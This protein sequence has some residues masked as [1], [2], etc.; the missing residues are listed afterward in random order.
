MNS[1]RVDESAGRQGQ[2]KH[3][4]WPALWA[5]TAA[6]GT[7]FC[8]YGFRK[9]FTAAAYADTKFQGLDFKTVLVIAQVFGYM[10]SKFLGIKIV[11]EVPPQRRAIS[12]LA[13]IV[14]AEIA[15]VLF[16]LVSRPWNAGCLILNGLSLGMVFGLVIGFLEG[17]R[18]T[19][20]LSAGLCASFIVADGVTKSV[21]AWLLKQGVAEDWM[22]SAAGALYFL[23]FLLCVVMLTRIAPP[24]TTDIIA[25]AERFTMTR[26]ERWSFILKYATGL[27]PLLIVFLLVTVVRSI[28]A[29]F[30]REIWIGLGAP[31]EPGTFTRSELLVAIGVLVINGSGVLIADNRRAFST[32]LAV[33]GLGLVLLA[34]ALV[35]WRLR[36]LD[37]F[38]FM[39]L[40]GLG[41]YLPYVS[42]HT[43]VFERFLAL[44]RDRGNLGFL[45]LVADSL[46]YL[47][48][49]A[50]MV[51]RNFGKA[52]GDVVAWFATA[53]WTAVALSS[54]CLVVSWRQ[55]AKIKTRNPEPA[56]VP[57]AP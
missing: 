42:M 32:S 18:L 15:L 4:W 38:G 3:E 31:A 19:E 41:L 23:P 35:A 22:P 57:G 29:D 53:C 26:A 47:G 33:C 25:R 37:E 14:L 8:M 46:G 34:A 54:I 17:R 56:T 27:L 9:P 40:V 39:V 45:L 30:A 12:L 24:T 28:R 52:P 51:I 20:A 10:L 48:Y 21:G 43:T 49:V 2:H 6:F 36:I 1:D 55:C 11:A 13:L 7:Y 44:T 50:V 16:G 5:V